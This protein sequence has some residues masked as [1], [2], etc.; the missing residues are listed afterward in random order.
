M[1]SLSDG[2]GLMGGGVRGMGLCGLLLCAHAPCFPDYSSSGS[3]GDGG[4]RK[5]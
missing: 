3:L 2:S 1:V 5:H 4:I